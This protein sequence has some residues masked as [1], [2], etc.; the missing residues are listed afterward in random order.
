MPLKLHSLLQD[1]NAV[2]VYRSAVGEKPT[3]ED[4]DR[5]ARSVLELME[6]RLDGERLV[7]K[8]NVTSGEHFADPDTGIT[9]HPAFIGGLIKYFKQNGANKDRIYIVEDPRN[10]NDHAPRHWKGTGYLEVAEETGAKLRCPNS[11]YCVKR[12]VPQPLIHPVR[13]V[14]RFA[15]GENTILVNVPKLKTHN[16]GIMTLGLKNMMGLDDVYERHYCS[17]AWN[18][19]PKE[20]ITD[21]KNKREWMDE[22]QHAVWQLGLAKR[23]A[24]L[25]KVIPTHLN[26][27]EGVV[28]RDG[29]GFQNGRNYSLGLVVAGVNIV[30]VDSVA[31]YLVGFDPAANITLKIA[32]E[33]GLGTNDLNRIKIYHAPDGIIQPCNDLT[34]YRSA[35]PFVVLRGIKGEVVEGF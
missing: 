32:A 4:Y 7:F 30:A 29:T 34:P 27:I 12:K 25:S 26:I 28:G 23:L 8:P 35:R 19:L 24:D 20:W 31:T 2:F 14:T 9:T 10:S 13:N 5:I 6:A 33:S 15:V 17:Q 22:S 16:L 3:H 18:D 21:Q 11:F 1:A